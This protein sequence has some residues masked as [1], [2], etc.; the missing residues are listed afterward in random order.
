MTK[1]KTATFIKEMPSNGISEQKLY[2]VSPP[3]QSYSWDEEE[4]PS[5]FDFVIVSAAYVPMSGPETYIFGAD[6]DGEVVNWGE[7]PGSY[8]GGLNHKQAL[9]GAGYTIA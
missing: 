5:E 7:L 1:T 8:K 6:S 4:T 3:M 9:G 2:Q